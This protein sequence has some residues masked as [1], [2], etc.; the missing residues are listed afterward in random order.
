[1]KH[2]KTFNDFSTPKEKKVKKEK[3]KKEQSISIEELIKQNSGNL[4]YNKRIINN[5]DDVKAINS[6]SNR[7][8]LR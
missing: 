4:S 5:L 7:E 8:H 2:L 3:P 6:G 1:M